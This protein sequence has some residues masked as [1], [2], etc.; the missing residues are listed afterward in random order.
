MSDESTDTANP[1]KG[2]SSA[3]APAANATAANVP[4]ANVSAAN[5]SAAEVSVADELTAQL[6]RARADYQ[7]LRKRTQV[8]IDNAVR[9]SLENL[10]QNLFVVVDNL[11]FALLVEPKSDDARQLAHGVEL[12]RKQFLHALAQEGAAPI[13]ESEQFDPKLH[14]AVSTTPSAEHAP[15]AIVNVLRR[16]WTWR[17]A[18]LRPTHVQVAVA[19]ATNTQGDQPSETA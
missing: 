11:D 15:G 17:G 9:R 2:E 1:S 18:V 12:T 6:A 14:E 4:A 13:P 10:L 8:D 7:N 5:V 3:A 19:A 16:G